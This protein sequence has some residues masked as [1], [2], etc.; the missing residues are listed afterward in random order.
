MPV[1]DNAFLTLRCPKGETAFLHA[2]WTQWK[3]RFS[4]EIFGTTGAV[5][6]NGL[7]GSYG[8]ESLTLYERPPEGGAP[9]E[10]AWEFPGPDESFGVELNE[11]MNTLSKGANRTRSLEETIANL[12]VVA[13]AYKQSK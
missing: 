9:K 6:V 1:E 2:S 8:V 5:V 12:E 13:A 10:T 3:N 11:F 7:G 4:Y